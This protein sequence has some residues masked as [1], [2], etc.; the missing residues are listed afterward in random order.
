MN[1][2]ASKP[3]TIY[4]IDIITS[5]ATL[6]E[7]ENN[8]SLTRLLNFRSFVWNSPAADILPWGDKPHSFGEI[9]PSAVAHSSGEVNHPSSQPM[10]FS[11]WRRKRRYFRVVAVK[12][13]QVNLLFLARL[14]KFACSRYTSLRR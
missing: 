5:L 1:F 10:L 3:H 6:V 9:K 4:K 13:N 7:I 11:Y 14:F 2:R 12:N 8:F